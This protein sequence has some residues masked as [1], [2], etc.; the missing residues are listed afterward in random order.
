MG[1]SERTVREERQ[2]DLDVEGV[3]ELEVKDE[4]E[5]SVVFRIFFPCRTDGRGSKFRRSKLV[6]ELFF[7]AP[8]HSTSQIL[9]EKLTR[10]ILLEKSVAATKTG[11]EELQFGFHYRSF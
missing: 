5:E 6:V 1:N 9:L 7:S 8:S 2:L 4:Q 11:E 10:Q 3:E